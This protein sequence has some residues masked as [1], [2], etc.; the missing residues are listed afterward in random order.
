MMENS[1]LLQNEGSYYRLCGRRNLLGHHV[2][3]NRMP[4]QWGLT[5]DRFWEVDKIMEKVRDYVFDEQ[6][7]TVGHEVFK[8]LR[9]LLS[10]VG[11]AEE[12]RVS[13]ELWR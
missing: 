8:S 3:L 4:T 5:R 10:A 6:C 2:S 7:R 11:Y 13:L 9:L 1:G 12:V